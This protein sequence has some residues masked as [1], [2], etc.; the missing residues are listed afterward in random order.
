M[1]KGDMGRYIPR[2]I[3]LPGGRGKSVRLIV[4]ACGLLFAAAV[5][6]SAQSGQTIRTFYV[7]ALSFNIPFSTTENDPRIVDVLLY[8]SSDGKNYRHVD[9]VRPTA[10]RF[11]FSTRG[12]G[13]YSFIV[14]TRDQSG[15]LHPADLREASPSIRVC[16]DTQ[17]PI[18]EQ[19]TAIP[20]RQGGS[21]GI[22]WQIKEENLKDIRA[23]YRSVRGGEWLPLF[24]PIQDE[25]THTWKPH[26]GGELE[27]RMWA[28]DKANQWSEMKSVHL[29][30]ADN[31]S[32]MRPPPEPAG[33]GKVMYVNSKTF[34]L[35]Y[36]LDQ[37]TV[38]PSS[39]KSVDIWKLHPGRAWQKCKE[40]GTPSGS[41]TVTVESAG[42]WGFRLIPRSGVGL[43][44]PDPRPGDAPDIWVEVDD[45][46]PQVHVTNVTVLQEPDGGY[47]TV[48]WKADDPFL[49]AMPITILWKDPH[50]SEWTPLARE[51][52]NTGSWRQRTDAL[53]LGGDR[54]EFDLQV[55][56][57][58]EAGNVGADQWREV[59]KVDLK[60]PRIKSIEVKPSGAPSGAGREV[61]GGPPSAPYRGQAGGRLP[62]SPLTTGGSLPLGNQPPKRSSPSPLTGS[63]K[64][65]SQ[66][67]R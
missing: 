51:L 36:Q 25:G 35:Q 33:G 8:V 32:G 62:Q 24:L 13:W 20:A 2:G 42:R 22:R 66:P 9:T 19:L 63:D 40:T 64:N 23:E 28:Q 30:V 53:N 60:I 39:V 6:L 31:V 41:A 67:R 43:A 44:E 52:P 58:D 15:V 56:A 38:G 55:T 61:Q 65:F 1:G 49:R 3:E 34:H 14:Q 16:V 17:S 5:G 47:L 48:Y 29:R 7:P 50:G 37:A 10:R 26:W 4:L 27:V 57:V 45:K 12:D 59:V 18:I 54:Y 46:P 11:Y 21:P